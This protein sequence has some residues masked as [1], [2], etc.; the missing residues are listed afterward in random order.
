MLLPILVFIPNAL[1]YGFNETASFTGSITDNM[2]SAWNSTWNN[3]LF[4][5][6]YSSFLTQPFI[7][8]GNLFGLPS[9][10]TIYY[11]LSY[12]LDIS[13]IWLVFDLVM[14]I[15][16]LVHRWLDKGIIE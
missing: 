9:T 16:L 8:I 6:A 7:Y 5:W 10:S 15:P 1:Y 2:I 11:C 3:A 12:W 14:Y 13:I 4:S